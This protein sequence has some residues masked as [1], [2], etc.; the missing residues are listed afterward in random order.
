MKLLQGIPSNSYSSPCHHSCLASDGKDRLGD[1][2]ERKMLRMGWGEGFVPQA[3]PI[4]M[5]ISVFLV[6]YSSSGLLAILF[7]LLIFFMISWCH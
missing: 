3:S 6:G 1:Q 2:S 7:I 5:H 4:S